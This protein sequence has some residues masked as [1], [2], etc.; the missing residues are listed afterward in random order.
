MNNPLVSV[1]VPCYN[2]ACYLNDALDSV[3]K[4][5]LGNWEC[6]I[7]NDGSKDDTEGVAND[8][9]NKDPRFIYVQQ[10]NRGLSSA[11]NVGL[12]RASGAY[13]QFLDSDDLIEPNKFRTQ[14][15]DLKTC[16]IS[17]SDYFAFVDGSKDKAPYRYLS[18]AFS[19]EKYKKEIIWDWEYRKS[20]PPHCPLFKKQLIDDHNLKFNEELPNHEDWEFWVKLFYFS[21]SFYFNE[22][23]LSFYRIRK[24]S[25][26]SEYNSMRKGFLKS[27]SFL[28][29]FFKNQKEKELY[30]LTKEK[31][32]EIKSRNKV[33]LTTK[34]KKLQNFLKLFYRTY[35]KKS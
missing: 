26:S 16:D 18:P 1:I 2:Q 25:M 3:Y 19:P 8:W 4:Q 24:G 7:V 11:R 31:Y 34:L 17:L 23:I 14:I 22:K 15:E 5:S 9:V 29:D 28:Q 12:K 10:K 35:V 6:I 27:A 33:P 21:D 20:F 32:K 30:K 13:V